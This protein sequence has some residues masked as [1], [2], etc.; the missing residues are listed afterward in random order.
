MKK[1]VVFVLC[2]FLSVMVKNELLTATEKNSWYYPLEIKAGLSS[3]FGEFRGNRVHTGVDLRT[4]MQTGYKV[5]AIDNGKI[6]RLSVKRLGFGNALYIEHPNG[7][8]SVYGHLDR[9]AEESLGLRSLVKR[10][11]KQRASKYP[12]NIYPKN[13]IPVKRGQL[14]AYSGETGYGLPHLHFEV[15]RGGAAPLDPFKHGFSYEDHTPPV[16]ESILIEPLGSQSWVDGEHFLREYRTEKQQGAYLVQHI[17]K[18]HGNVRFTAAAYD[19][20]GAQNKCAVD[21]IDLYIAYSGV[22]KLDLYIDKEQFFHNQFNQVTYDTNHR[23]GLVYNYNLT[24]LSNPTQ[25]YYRL[26][27]LSPSHFPYRQVFAKDKGIWDTTLYKEGLHTILLEIYD[28]MGNLSTAQMQVYVEH[29][30]VI[31]SLASTRSQGKEWYMEVR[32]F[33]GF[34]EVLCQSNIPLQSA[35]VLEVT[36]KNST[37]AT[38]PLSPKAQ[39]TFATTYDLP[40]GK[41]GMLELTV[42]AMTQNG[43]QFKETRQYPVNKITAKR[44]GTVSYGNKVSMSFPAEALYEDIFA[45]IWPTSAYELTEGLPLM[46]EVYDFRPAGVPLEKKGSIRIQYP[47]NVKDPKTLGIFW[48]DTIK[49][50]WYFMDDKHETKSRSLTAPIIYPSIYAVLQDTVHPVISDLKPESGNTASAP[51]LTLSAMIKD[52]GKGVDEATIVMKL[53]GREVDGEYD[54][55]RRKF[56]YSLTKK[57]PAG[58]HTLSV[59][60]SDKAGNSAK[61]Q[62]STFTVR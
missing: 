16:I 12:G 10:Y 9:F 21:R 28:V 22:D 18:V 30:R 59:Q 11:Q 29:Q 53:D 56:S 40:S 8:M 14:I 55:D 54:P 31:Q 7:L 49:K 4:N 46:S 24:R 47:Q 57:L 38:L 33:Q 42:T 44:G 23:G 13:P 26:Y 41:N 51:Q 2:L 34:L 50:R 36:Q 1:I 19:Q 58:K 52:V 25:Y 48:W 45:N 17:P 35:P 37:L 20:I 61:P 62:T 32:E 3:N 43:E 6:V 27:N 15:R 5:Y 39:N 60:A